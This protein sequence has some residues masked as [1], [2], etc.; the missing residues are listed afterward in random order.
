MVVVD[1]EDLGPGVFGVG[2]FAHGVFLTFTAAGDDDARQ[3]A[4]AFTAESAIELG[5]QLVRESI[6]Y[7]SE[8]QRTASMN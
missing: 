3:V 6:T 7:L 2:Q 4:I 1:E 5:E 8:A